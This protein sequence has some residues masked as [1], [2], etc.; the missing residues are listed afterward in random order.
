M[1]AKPKV[2]FDTNVYLSAIIFGGTPRLCLDMARN[3]EIELYTS[4]AILLELLNKLRDKF[5][6]S[7]NEIKDVLEGLAKFVK[8]VLPKETLEVIT[9]DLTDNRILEAASEAKVDF[10]VSGDKKHILPLKEFRGIKIVSP[11][12]FIKQA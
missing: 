2:V 6:W 1:L 11:A 12:D 10:I 5:F 7:E 8:L 3:Q 9:K 4:R